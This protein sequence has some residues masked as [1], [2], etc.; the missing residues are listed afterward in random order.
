[1]VGFQVPAVDGLIVDEL[2][3]WLFP[4][5]A[6]NEG[7]GSWVGVVE[8]INSTT[9]EPRDASVWVS[10]NA[11]VLHGRPYIEMERP[12]LR[13]GVDVYDLP[14][15]GP[16]DYTALAIDVLRKLLESEE[17][18]HGIFTLLQEE[19]P[20]FLRW[21]P[22]GVVVYQYYSDTHSRASF[23]G[24]SAYNHHSLAEFALPMLDE[25]GIEYRIERA[26]ISST[27]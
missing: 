26:P 4:H 27:Y 22:E 2:L 13:V 9:D 10:H 17:F 8:I 5:L 1:M 20:P 7:P 19:C 11:G 12:W 14:G 23:W 15:V 21:S 25:M 6:R 3:D 24:C 18:S 16:Q